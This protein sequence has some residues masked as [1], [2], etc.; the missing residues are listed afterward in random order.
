MS[1]TVILAAVA[2]SCTAL[3]LMAV[4]GCG[5]QSAGGDRSGRAPDPVAAA[6]SVRVCRP[7][8]A[9]GAASYASSLYVEN[10]LK[11]AAKRTGVIQQV[12]VD[13]GVEVRAGQALALL[14]TDVAAPESRMAEQEFRL[15]EADYR[16]LERL[17]KDQVVSP[18]DFERA[19]VARD[20]AAANVDLARAFL[21]RC[22]I[23]APFDGVVVE[24]WAVAGRRVQEEDDTPLFRIVSSA[25]LRA[26]VDVP[27]ER[28]GALREGTIAS[29]EPA[30]GPAAAPARVV[31]VAPAAD[32]ASGTVSV[33]V[34]LSPTK[35]L[36]PGVTVA[37]RF[38]E[39][40]PQRFPSV[41][42]PREALR[43]VSAVAGS[44]ATV[45]VVID[46][47]A[48]ARRVKVIET[49]GNAV[50]VGG[51]IR[52]TDAVVLAPPSGL[53]DG[54]AVEATEAGS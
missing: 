8:A 32:P 17:R 48:S 29:V 22:T 27:E 54:V 19:E 13:R 42:I 35:G 31:F 11:I 50:I 53:A 30:G 4:C 51:E 23:R 26:R 5:P 7:E 44:E 25:P 33:I 34:Q 36:R 14:E 9:S 12:L 52:A 15:A 45:F 38:E 21:E 10:D 2:V 40:A 41:R 18:Q 16:R 24:R 28:L 6:R 3:S 49:S 43:P 39:E 37:V 20:L 1:R 46:R 47:K